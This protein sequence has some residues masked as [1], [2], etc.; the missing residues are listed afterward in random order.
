MKVYK[1]MY[2]KDG[3]KPFVYISGLPLPK[4][5][6]GVVRNSHFIEC[7]FH[8]M[9]KKVK[10]IGCKFTRCEGVEALNNIRGD[11]VK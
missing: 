8:P 2:F 10:F 3:G 7:D 6:D 9:C 4:D 5:V 1:N 11:I